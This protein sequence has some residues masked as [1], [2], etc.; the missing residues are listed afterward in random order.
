MTNPHVSPFSHHLIPKPGVIMDDV[1]NSMD[2][3]TPEGV[4]N[5]MNPELLSHRSQGSTANYAEEQ[6]RQMDNA[7]AE[8][9]EKR[10]S[11][12]WRQGASMVELCMVLCSVVQSDNRLDHK[13]CDLNLALA[14]L[15]G[16]EFLSSMVS[17]AWKT[18][19]YRDLRKLGTHVNYL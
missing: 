1:D 14:L 11:K 7:V 9:L 16:D 17:D 2:I 5:S 10:G 19:S 4:D 3:D 18:N 12:Y 13:Y 6:H 8:Q 15:E